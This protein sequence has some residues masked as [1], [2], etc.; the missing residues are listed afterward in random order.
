MP[1]QNAAQLLKAV[2]QD[3]ALKQKLKATANPEAF[4]Q[5]AQERGYDF[6][7]DE[8]ETELDKLSEEDLAGIVNPGWGPRRHIHPR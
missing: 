8:L 3:Q 7:V 6:T 5:I 1:R 4:V 2:K